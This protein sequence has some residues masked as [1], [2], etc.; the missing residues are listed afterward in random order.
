MLQ[1]VRS[2]ENI[3]ISLPMKDMSVQKDTRKVEEEH[4]KQQRKRLRCIKGVIT[5]K[6]Q[7]DSFRKPKILTLMTS[8]QTSKEN[9]IQCPACDDIYQKYD[10]PA[11]D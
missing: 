9:I 2:T 11:E 10:P 6:L 4:L 8:D 3:L 7:F 1:G 5:K